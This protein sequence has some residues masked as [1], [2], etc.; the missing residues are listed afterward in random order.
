MA[1]DPE[2]TSL[3]KAF[4]RP[5]LK[6]ICNTVAGEH[7]VDVS[8]LRVKGRKMH[9]ARDVAIYASRECSGLRLV[10]IGAYFG[11]IRRSTVSS[12]CH[13]VEKRMAKDKRWRRRILRLIQQA[14]QSV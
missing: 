7:E 12:A 11:A 2:V 13:R 14:K 5:T 10:E 8:S 6:A 3:M 1:E 4:R 9:D